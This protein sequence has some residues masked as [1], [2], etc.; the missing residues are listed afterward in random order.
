MYDGGLFVGGSFTLASGVDSSRIAR[1]GPRL[2]VADFNG[3]GFVDFFHYLDFVTAFENGDTAAD[4]NGDA[5]LD[6]FDYL[7]FV[8]AFETGC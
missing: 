7:D 5:F 8:E 4:I 6:F 1:W 2:C 3:D